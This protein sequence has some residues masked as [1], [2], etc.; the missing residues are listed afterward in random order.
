MI[1]AP[2][3]QDIVFFMKS[4]FEINI[5]KEDLEKLLEKSKK[6]KRLI[7]SSFNQWLVVLETNRTTLQDLKKD[8]LMQK[9]IR[10]VYYNNSLV[11]HLIELKDELKKFG[12]EFNKN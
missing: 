12:F 3:I 4:Q 11:P 2:K 5:K 6:I 8:E 10:E 7:Y 9:D 1:E